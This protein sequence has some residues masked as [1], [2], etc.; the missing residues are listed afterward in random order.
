MNTINP[1]VQIQ[2]LIDSI[3]IAE[4][5]KVEDLIK[6][7]I[8]VIKSEVWFDQLPED[9]EE[10]SLE[11]ELEVKSILENIANG[12]QTYAW[13]AIKAE[14]GMNYMETSN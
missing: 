12:E 5:A 9:E 13:A 4:L 10:I 3:G 14:L 1:L 2:V 11:E 6:T 8:K 7:R